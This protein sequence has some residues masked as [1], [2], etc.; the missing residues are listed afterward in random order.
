MQE[1]Y[2]IYDCSSLVKPSFISELNKV[3]PICCS[4]KKKNKKK[5][6]IISATCQKG[7]FIE[8]PTEKRKLLL[9]IA[10]VSGQM[11]EDNGPKNT[12]FSLHRLGKKGR[13]KR[14]LLILSAC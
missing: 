8:K 6:K 7:F 11:I 1:S 5:S 4:V 3:L 13:Q 9:Q 12:I 10:K 14:E 2:F